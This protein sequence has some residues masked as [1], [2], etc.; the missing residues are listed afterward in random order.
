MGNGFNL[1]DLLELRE[2]NHNKRCIRREYELS[3]LWRDTFL[4]S[5]CR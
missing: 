1:G 4:G 2:I 3:R 5:W